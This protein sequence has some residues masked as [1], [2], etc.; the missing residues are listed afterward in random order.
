MTR[1]QM[2]RL[3]R[4]GRGRQTLA[5]QAR[6]ETELWAFCVHIA[7]MNSA[8]DFKVSSR[9]W[10]YLLEN[11]GTITKGDLDDAERLI[12]DCR[13]D[14]HLPLDI[15]AVD[16]KRAAKGLEELDDTD[17]EAEAERIVTYAE[18]AHEYYSP[19]SFWDGLDVYV[20]MLVEK[21]DLKSLFTAVCAEY[22]VPLANAGGWADINGRAAIL[23]RFAE[24]E[25]RG[26]RCVLS[27]CGDHDPGGLNISD[28]LRS[29]LEDLVEAVR[30]DFLRHNL[31]DLAM[32]VQRVPERLI[33]D[34]FGLN[35][36]FIEA[37]GL[38]WIDN[39]ETASGGRLDDPNHRD[40]YKPYV[41]NYI[42]RFG[43]RKVEA[44]AMVIR[45]A[46]GRELCRQ[47]ILRYVPEDALDDYEERLALARAELR[48]AITR[49]LG[50][51]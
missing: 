41:Q 18:R 16:D 50:R 32:A 19:L 23:R 12:N 13:K 36:D 25:C 14:G 48:T 43:A 22:H 31:P 51:A 3:P 28:F 15:C 40:H 1:P 49:K 35:Y 24:A 21:I 39:L 9:G 17:I 33:I 11:E 5:A 44:N 7:Q 42:R 47:A 37:Q 38:T 26:Q 27:Y 30:K 2:M 20:E 46:A 29:N 4:R 6:Y 8:L 34:R 45:P 10:G